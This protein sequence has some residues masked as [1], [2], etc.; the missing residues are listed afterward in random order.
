MLISY[1]LL[2][3]QVLLHPILFPLQLTY[4]CPSLSSPSVIFVIYCTL[5]TVFVLTLEN[6]D[7]KIGQWCL[8]TY[9]H[10]DQK[11]KPVP[12]RYPED[13]HIHCQFPKNPLDSLT[14]LTPLP[15]DFIHTKKLTNECLASMKLNSDGFLWPEEE[16]LFAHVMKLNEAALA[17]DELEHSNFCSYYFS[18][19]IIP[20][21]P[22]EPWEYCNIPIPP[23]I[24]ERVIQLLRDKIA[25]RLYEPAQSSYYSKWFCV[26]KKNGKIRIV[27]DLQPLNKV[28]IRDAGVPP[29]LDDFVK[30]FAGQQ[31]Y[32]VFDLFSGFDAHQLHPDS[33]D[34]TSFMT[35]LGLLRHTAMP[36]GYTNSPSEFQNCTSFILQDEIPH[37]ANVFIDDLTIKG[38]ETRYNDANGNAE[39][40][41]ANPGIRHFIWGHAIDVH[42]IMHCFAHA[43]GTFSGLKTQLCCPCVLILGQECHPDGRSPDHGKVKKIL[44][45]PPLA[46]PKDV[47]SFLG[48][49]GTVCIWIANY[50]LLA[51]PLI[52]LYRKDTP[53][54]WDTPQEDTFNALK[55][56]VSSAPSLHPIN[57]STDLPVVLS[58]DTSYIAIG[59]ILSQYNESGH[60]CPAHYGS[61]PINEHESRYS[62]PKLELYG[63]FHVLHHYHLFL[64]G[65]KNLHVE[66]DA[67]YIKGMLNDPDL[68]PNATINHWIKGILLFNFK[69]IH[70]AAARHQ[71][72]DVLSRSQP[73]EEEIE[74]GERDAED[75]GEWLEDLLFCT[76]AHPLSYAPITLPSFLSQDTTQDVILRQMT[77]LPSF[78]SNTTHKHFIRRS[79]QFFI[80]SSQLFKRQG[81]CTP[82]KVIFDPDLHAQILNQAH[83]DLGHRGVFGVF[84]AVRDCFYWPQMYSDVA[85]HIRSC[86]ECQICSNRKVEIPLTVSPSPQIFVKI[87]VD[88]MLMPKACGYRYLVA[89]HDDLSLAAEGRAL[90]HA[91]SDSLAK[92]FW[93][94]I[95]CH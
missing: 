79:L 61:L 64:Y 93:E 11:V 83:E 17:F 32:T 94:E 27:H 53:F 6:L 10:V 80:R 84:Q 36:Q 23:G 45:W 30:P 24:H 13:A 15:P 75:A 7:D 76:A 72:P 22:H 43:G 58:V 3:F 1:L 89:A 63:L 59:F 90:K 20:I 48:L 38:P 26:M 82:T 40:L 51:R 9:K 86:H 42:R 14:R 19:Y 29:I 52:N 21:L 81:P 69:L 8:G 68:Q 73:T 77:Q 55:I 85:H 44:D 16:K 92:F 88:V 87:Y 33:R 2:L 65:V 66:V 35:P 56:T 41:P 46:M 34:L 54:I 4:I 28:T 12:G 50:S 37:V 70:V 49:C 18:P 5:S 31:C 62:Q 74:D 60:K 78:P 25:A 95:I 39:T 47:R 71:G 67:K 91:S 57:Y